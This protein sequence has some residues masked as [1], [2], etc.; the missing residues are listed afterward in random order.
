MA[1][2]ATT[3]K[4][5]VLNQLF[6]A[7]KKHYGDPGTPAER[8]VLEQM[9]YAVLREGATRDEADKAFGRLRTDFFDWN[10][11][12]V[13]SAHEVEE[14]LD[15]LPGAGPRAQRVID[16]LQEVFEST[17]SFDLEALHKKG[18]KQSAKQVGRYQAADDFTVAWVTQQSLGGHAIPVDAP[19]LRVARRLG[20]IDGEGGDPE[21]ARSALEHQVP[22]AKGAQFT[23]YLSLLARDYCWEEN[24]NCAACPMRSEC[25]TGLTDERC[26]PGGGRASRPKP[27]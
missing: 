1:M 13:S 21:A 9:V 24:P 20:L 25:L 15:G 26:Q 11:V 10:E 8:P 4:Q 12:R 18:L 6:A 3:N 22:K 23:E 27:R 19:T 17:Y 14:A 7:L 5:R 16:L 2:P